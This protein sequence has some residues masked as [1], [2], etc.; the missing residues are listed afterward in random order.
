MVGQ[1]GR[2]CE[3]GQVFCPLNGRRMASI[4]E[5]VFQEAFTQNMA[6]YALGTCPA[7]KR[8]LKIAFTKI[9]LVFWLVG[10]KEHLNH[11]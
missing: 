11:F 7:R 9:T 8:I 4:A 1:P 10:Y 3:N 6:E 2:P 5:R